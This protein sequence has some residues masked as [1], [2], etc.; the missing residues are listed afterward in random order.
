MRIRL[1]RFD[2]S[3]QYVAGSEIAMADT[4]SRFPLNHEPVLIDS[5]DVVEQHNSHVVET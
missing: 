4:L 2:Y 5:A 3:E 1:M